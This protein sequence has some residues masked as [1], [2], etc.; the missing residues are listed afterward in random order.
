MCLFFFFKQKTAYEIMP[1]LVGSEM[2][3]RD[4]LGSEPIQRAE[5]PVDRVHGNVVE[6]RVHP[7][8]AHLRGEVPLFW[9]TRDEDESWAGGNRH[10]IGI[11]DVPVKAARDHGGNDPLAR[12][13]RQRVSKPI[14]RVDPVQ[15]TREEEPRELQA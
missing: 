11:G 8:T 12:L 15:T 7:A 4:S 14:V 10:L 5:L 3:I 13:E 6:P 9:G 1:S 2:C